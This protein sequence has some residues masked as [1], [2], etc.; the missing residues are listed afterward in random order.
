MMRL[1]LDAPRHL[2]LADMG[3]TAAPRSRGSAGLPDGAVVAVLETFETEARSWCRDR[4]IDPDGSA[5]CIMIGRLG[6]APEKYWIR[7]A[8]QISLAA[9]DGLAA[10]RSRHL[11]PRHPEV[12]PGDIETRPFF[13]R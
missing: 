8:R 13:G 2:G 12:E 7:R 9:E 4:G 3:M 11:S 6:F 5:P 10:G 1:D